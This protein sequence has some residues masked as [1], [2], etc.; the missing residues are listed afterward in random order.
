MRKRRWLVVLVLALAI[1]VIAQAAQA[2]GALDPTWWKWMV[3]LLQ[4][5]SGAWWGY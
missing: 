4:E 5:W 3:R 2:A 1:L